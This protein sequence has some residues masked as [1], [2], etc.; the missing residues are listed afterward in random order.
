V[1]DWSS[2]IDLGK[3][4]DVV[5]LDFAKAFDKV[6]INLLI[7][8]LKTQ[9]IS[10]RLLVWIAHFISDRKFVVKVNGVLSDFFDVLSGVPQGFV[11]GPKLFLL[12]TAHILLINLDTG[13][14]KFIREKLSRSRTMFRR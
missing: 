7:A 5:Y 9:G 8:K 3:S 12:Y 4:V 14:F 13:D 1:N 2:L 10:G 11:L 6:P